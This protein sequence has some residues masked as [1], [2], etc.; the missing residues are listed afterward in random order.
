M[1]ARSRFVTRTDPR[2]AFSLVELLVVLAIIAILIS[3]LLPAVQ[4]ARESA[5]RTQCRNNLKQIG[6][7]L[8]SFEG[9]FGVY[10]ASGWTEASRFNP[11]G[12][13][14]SWRAAL[15]PFLEQSALSSEYDFSKDWWQEDNLS[16]ARIGLSAYQ[17]PSVPSQPAITVA[18]A[19]TPRPELQ[20]TNPLAGSDYEAIMLSLIHI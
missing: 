9:T 3:L 16:L 1:L 13:F 8:N 20:L 6:I 5:R 11:D 12:A 7:A 18:V 15:L 4:E 19:K 10:P 17:C 14:V 2:R